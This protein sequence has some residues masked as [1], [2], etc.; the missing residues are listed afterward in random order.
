MMH[1]SHHLEF[2]ST[3]PPPTYHTTARQ[4]SSSH[5]MSPI[6]V[7]RGDDDPWIAAGFLLHPRPRPT[8]SPRLRHRRFLCY[9]QKCIPSPRV[10][11]G[12][13]SA[14]FFEGS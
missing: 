8:T 14:P 3:S 5:R 6:L 1:R 2:E 10:T 11:Q 7:A 12:T 9:H 4:L 13:V